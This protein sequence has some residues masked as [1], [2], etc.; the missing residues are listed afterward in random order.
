GAARGG[1]RGPA[2]EGAGGL[3]ANRLLTDRLSRHG[4]GEQGDQHHSE[5][6]S[7][8][9]ARLLRCMSGRNRAWRAGAF[10]P[11]RDEETSGKTTANEAGSKRGASPHTVRR[12][13]LDA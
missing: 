3:E 5:C 7:G 13:W 2:V 10:T 12:A 11:R 6:R 4:R 1:A 9:H 8:S